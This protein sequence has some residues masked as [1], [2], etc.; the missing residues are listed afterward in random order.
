MKCYTTQIVLE[1]IKVI[2]MFPIYT[3]HQWA[4]KIYITKE[5]EEKHEAFPDL[6]SWCLL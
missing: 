4:T 3:K 5:N 2:K 6:F 1:I